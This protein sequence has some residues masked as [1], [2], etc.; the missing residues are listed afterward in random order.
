MAFVTRRVVPALPA[1]PDAAVGRTAV[2]GGCG[3]AEDGRA[4]G[5]GCGR[6]GRGCSGAGRPVPRLGGG[7]IAGERAYDGVRLPG[8]ESIPRSRS[9]Q[10]EPLEVLELQSTGER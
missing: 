1:G 8:A 2:F 10:S 6:V 9:L 4:G 7:G 3:E 5:E